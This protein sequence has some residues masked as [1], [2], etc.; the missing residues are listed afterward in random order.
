MTI[1]KNKEIVLP[2]WLVSILASILV[3]VFTAWGIASAKAATLEVKAQ[4][5][6]RDIK[7]LKSTKVNRGE[8]DLVLEKLNTIER[9][10]D[11]VEREK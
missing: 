5:N 4:T 3:A 1:S 6:E 10:L 2:V 8:F 9:K 7:E 11:R